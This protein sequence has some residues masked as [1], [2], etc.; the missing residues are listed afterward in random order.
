MWIIP[1]I[2]GVLLLEG[3]WVGVAL[4]LTGIIT[5]YLFGGGVTSLLAVPVATWNTL[6]NFPLVAIPLYIFLGEV[7]VFSGL[8]GRAY[9]ALSPFFERF[10]GKLLNTNVV[11]CAIMGAVVGSSMVTAATVSAIAYPELSARGY[12]RGPLVGNLAGAGTLGSFIPPSLGLIIYGAWVQVS[13]GALFIAAIFPALIT[14]ALFMAFLMVMCTVRKDIVP[15]SGEIMP[16]GR[17]IL[18][19]KD[20]WPMLLLIFSVVGIIYLGIATPTEAGGLAA[21]IALI[22]SFA[23]RTFNFKALYNALLATARVSGM[24]FFII[25]G[26]VI[27]SISVSV[28]GLPR[29]VLLFIGESGLSSISIILL[30][31]LTYL[32]LGC[33]FDF[34]SMLVMTLPFVFPI[35]SNLG[36]DPF[37]FGIVLVIVGEMGLLTPPV[38][39]NLYVLQG[40]TG[41]KVSLGEVAKGSIPYFLALGVVLGFITLFPELTTWLPTIM[42]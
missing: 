22:M 17:A 27:F 12:K 14:V 9:H 32:I 11:V 4:G 33:F 29:Q 41:G 7:M 34:I 23:Y 18:H 31:Y 5:L 26:A 2:L 13:V 10:P 39:M 30:I 3:V 21:F 25:V 20:I 24:I 40:I 28:I 15:P 16:L 19:T 8:A 1:L 6:F 36:Y 37:W 42:K 38:G 35:I